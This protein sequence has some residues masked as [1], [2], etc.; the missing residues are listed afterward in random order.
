LCRDFFLVENFLEQGGNF[1]FQLREEKIG[2]RRLHVADLGMDF[3]LRLSIVRKNTAENFIEE[4][5]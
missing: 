5:G 1:L 3:A 4:H 2:R